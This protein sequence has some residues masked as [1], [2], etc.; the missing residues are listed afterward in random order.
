[1]LYYYPGQLNHRCVEETKNKREYLAPGCV[2]VVA[3]RLVNSSPGAEGR[4]RG[5]AWGSELCPG[6]G[7]GFRNSDI[8]LC[9]EQR[10]AARVS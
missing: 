8:G 7:T 5:D 10:A 3:C 2:T 1:M 4:G 9:A 6:T